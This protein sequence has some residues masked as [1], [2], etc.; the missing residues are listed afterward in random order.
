MNSSTDFQAL[1]VKA[2]SPSGEIDTCTADIDMWPTGEV[3][4][5]AAYSS[6]N[7]KDAMACQGHR[8]IIKQLPHVPGI[9]VAG[10][11]IQSDSGDWPVGTPVVV[12]GYDLGQRSF[13]GWSQF[14]R[15]P[16]QWIVPLP[17]GLTLRES[18]ILGTAGFTAA[19]CVRALQRNNCHVDSGPVVVTGATGGVGC[20]AVAMLDRLGY[21]VA[22]VTGKQERADW[23]RQIGASEVLDRDDIQGPA[24]RPLL[25]AKWAGGVDTVGGELLTSILKSTCYG[26]TVTACGL[27]AGSDLNMTLYPYLL[28]GVSL[29]GVASADCPMETRLAIWR[30]LAGELKPETLDLIAEEVGFSQMQSKVIS[31]L[32]GQATGRVVLNIPQP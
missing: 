27:V 7:Y 15:V 12:T 23:L 9:D 1:L 19:Q 20:L 8:G 16:A 32:D 18:M 24:E 6:L 25:S 29:C 2:E 13:G 26:G 28:R 21:E 30:Q 22:A 14:V 31:M 5:Q 17:D 3:V 4:I 11:V 10:I